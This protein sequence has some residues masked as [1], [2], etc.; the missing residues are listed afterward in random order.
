PATSKN[1]NIIRLSLNSDVNDE[2]ITKIIEVC[3]DAV[4]CGDFYFR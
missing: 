2:Q 4:N 3:S 1:K